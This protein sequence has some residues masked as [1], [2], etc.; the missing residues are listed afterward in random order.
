M[1]LGHL[2]VACAQDLS[3]QMI[4]RFACNLLFVSR[5]C[6]ARFPADP[7]CLD[8]AAESRQ[9]S[10]IL[11]LLGGPREAR[12]RLTAP[13]ALRRRPPSAAAAL[14]AAGPRFARLFARPGCSPRWLSLYLFES[15]ALKQAGAQAHTHAGTHQQLQRS[16]CSRARLGA[17]P[18]DPSACTSPWHGAGRGPQGDVLS[19]WPTV[20]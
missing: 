9:L 4:S 1:W 7:G 8:A 18:D 11:A 5:T 6:R 14:R 3:D 13:G 15:T 16:L 2:C 10:R 19:K 17:S 12:G 20:W